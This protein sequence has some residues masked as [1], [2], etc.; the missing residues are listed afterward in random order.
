MRVTLCPFFRDNI[1]DD[2]GSVSITSNGAQSLRVRNTNIAIISGSAAVPALNFIDDGGADTGIYHPSE[3]VLGFSTAGT[4]RVRIGSSGNVGIGTTSPG[5]KL[6]VNGNIIA[7]DPTANNHV[8][9][10]G[11][12][13]SAVVGCGSPTQISSSSPTT[14]SQDNGL[15]YCRDLVESGQSD[16]HLPTIEE[17]QLFVRNP[18]NSEFLWTRTPIFNH[19]NGARAYINYQLST[20]DWLVN[21]LV[22]PLHCRCV[23]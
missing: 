9:T 2:L 21:S 4:E 20:G 17:I 19:L 22:L 16:W 1:N 12:V 3:N 5:A 6:E 15:E 7:A 14:L 10:K 8:A 11:F 13:E 23:R 18:S